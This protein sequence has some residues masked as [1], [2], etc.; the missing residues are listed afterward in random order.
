MTECEQFENMLKR[1]KIEYKMVTY[2][3]KDVTCFQVEAGYIGFAS[4]ITFDP[5]TGLLLSIEAHEG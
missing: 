1:A 2:M 3:F 5:D 4:Q